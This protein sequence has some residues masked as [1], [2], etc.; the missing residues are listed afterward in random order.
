MKA[1]N[2]LSYHIINLLSEGEMAMSNHIEQRKQ[3]FKVRDEQV[4]VLANALVDDKTNEILFDHELDN[5]A[6][7]LAFEKFRNDNNIV[8]PEEI[9]SFRKKYKLS[10][11][12]LASLLGI[13]SATVAR[14]E[15]GALPSESISNL[16]KQLIDDDN[17]FT[18]FY[19]QNND[20]LSVEDGQKVESVL[21]GMQGMLKTNMVLQAYLVRNE[22]D[23][24][25]VNDG[26]KEFNF[27]KFENMVIYFIKNSYSLSKT[28]LNK[29]LFYGDFGFFKDNTVS[30]SG[31]R[32][33]HDY[34]GPVPSDFELLYTMLRDQNII[35]FVPFSN[36]RGEELCTN[37]EF[38]ETIFSENELNMLKEVSDKFKDYNAKSIT[39]YSHKEKAYQ[40]TNSKQPISYEYAFE[41]N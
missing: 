41:L 9:V 26:F 21:A 19:R 4:T 23:Q 5:K 34:F 37:R 28:R 7:N 40:E 31:V 18:T 15:K 1:T 3:T 33:I 16:L 20:K 2:H 32:Y 17:T 12:A 36:G 22:N 39:E 10:Q 27:K 29:L 38:D 14:Y 25:N 13:G 30:I 8:S 11:R 6:I 35:D 24:A